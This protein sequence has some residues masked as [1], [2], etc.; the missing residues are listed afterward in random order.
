MGR[1]SRMEGGQQDEG[2]EA[3]A[4]RRSGSRAGAGRPGRQH[5]TAAMGG[6]HH[7]A[8]PSAGRDGRTWPHL[9]GASRTF[10]PCSSTPVTKRTSRPRIRWK[11]AAASAAMVGYALPMCGAALT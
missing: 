10:S 8:F 2:S 4:R 11:R 5:K 9:A 1:A 3:C 7:N 6:A